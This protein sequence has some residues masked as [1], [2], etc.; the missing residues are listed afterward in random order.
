MKRFL[1]SVGALV[2]GAILQTTTAHA[3][4]RSFITGDAGWYWR[5]DVGAT[6]PMD[7]HIREFGGF[8]SGQKLSYDTGMGVDAAFGYMFNKY[9]GTEVEGGFTWNSI[10]SVE[11]ASIHDTSFGTAPILANVIL[12]YPIAQ[13]RVTPYVGGGV[14]GAGTFFDTDSFFR[15]VP[16]GSIEL[17]GSESDFAFAWQGLAGLRVALNDKMSIGVGYRYLHVDP[18]TFTFDPAHHHGGPS[19]DLGIS[20]HE[21]H[22]VAVTFLMKL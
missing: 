9:V 17:H 8:S 1:V 11:G 22:M 13:T 3:Q 21:S 7:G 19:L 4:Y 20:A 18:S 16:G 2:F 5:A 15:T 12:Q 6:I 10:N 14:G